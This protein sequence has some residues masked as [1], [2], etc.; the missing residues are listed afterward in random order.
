MAEAGR[1]E[2][3]AWSG[4]VR[5]RFAKRVAWWRETVG[6]TGKGKISD[7]TIDNCYQLF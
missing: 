5:G 4:A 7:K 3:R 1:W 6:E 2:G